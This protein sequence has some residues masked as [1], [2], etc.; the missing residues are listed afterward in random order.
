VRIVDPIA[1]VIAGL[2]LAAAVAIAM[3]VPARRATSVDPA[4]VLRQE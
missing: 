2:G 1:F 4:L 3:L